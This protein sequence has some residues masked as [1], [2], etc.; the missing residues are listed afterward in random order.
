MRA[1][2][3]TR[4]LTALLAVA[5]AL[6]G[7]G[8]GTAGTDLPSDGSGG[9]IAFFLPHPNADRYEGV[10]LPYFSQRVKQLCGS[11]EVDYYNAGNKQEV[12]DQ[13]VQEAL[14]KGAKALVVDV[15][16]S[17]HSTQVV[18]M[19][20]RAKVPVIAYD[21]LIMGAKLDYYVSFDAVKVGAQQGAAL[22]EAMGGKAS[23][24]QI[25]WVNGPQ[26]DNNAVKFKQGA[27]G[28]LVGKVKVAAEFT[29]PGPG[30]DPKAVE[31]WLAKTLPSLDVKRISGAY[32]VDDA[33][34]GM[35][36]DALSAAGIKTLPPVTGQNADIS[37]MQRILVG[38][39][40]MTAYK[41][42][43]REAAKAA[44]VAVA[45]LRGNPPKAPAQV[46]NGAGQQPAFLLES[47]PVTRKSIAKVIEDGFVTAGALCAAAYTDACRQA[48][49]AD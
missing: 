36:A 29:M 41:P 14:G 32:S 8:A 4:R 25:L 19:A 22:L 46:D 45:L 44:E 35:I 24:G 10:D 38:K 31:S 21:R 26:S 28:T 30:Y 47:V 9:R 12:Q 2:T 27:Q 11:C 40:Y 34:A 48:G 43:H 17:K 39:Q 15:V 23:S 18:E 33:S 16:D 13:Q 6:G 42:I 37:G 49:I 5:A 3:T 1:C 7:C 20:N